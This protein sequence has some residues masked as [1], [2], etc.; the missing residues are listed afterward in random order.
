MTYYTTAAFSRNT[1]EIQ[2]GQLA[3]EMNLRYI[4]HKTAMIITMPLL[5]YETQVTHLHNEVED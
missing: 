1:I 3:M 2:T 5:I 4:Q